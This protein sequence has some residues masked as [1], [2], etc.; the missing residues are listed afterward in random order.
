MNCRWEETTIGQRCV[1]CDREVRST[2]WLPNLAAECRGTR[3]PSGPCQ[4]RGAEIDRVK[5]AGC[6]CQEPI[7]VYSCEVLG[8]CSETF[9]GSIPCCWTCGKRQ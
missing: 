5:P 1:V 8:R 9:A 4:Y 2:R 6:K 7:P 3:L